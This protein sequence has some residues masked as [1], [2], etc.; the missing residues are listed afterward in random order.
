MS[1]LGSEFKAAHPEEVGAD[2]V[3][4][5]CIGGGAGFIGSHIA[6][7]LMAEVFIDEAFRNLFFTV[8]SFRTISNGDLIFFVRVVML[9][10][11]IGKKMN[12]WHRRNF[13]MN[14]TKLIYAF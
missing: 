3:I 9:F 5:V 7:R 13:V 14:F 11:L 1:S 8:V 12:S 4:R 10:V 2:G 6:K